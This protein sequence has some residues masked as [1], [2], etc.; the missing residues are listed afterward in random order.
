[1]AEAC[2]ARDAL[3]LSRCEEEMDGW[4]RI[5]CVHEHVWE[6]R[7]C[8]E[9][10]ARTP[11]DALCRRCFDLGHECRVQIARIGER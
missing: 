10:A 11:A 9:H 8:A 1:M 4:F 6:S 3:T 2:R 5:G 7:L